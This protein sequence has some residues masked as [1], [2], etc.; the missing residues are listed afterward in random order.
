M[1]LTRRKVVVENAPS[2]RGPV[3]SCES[4]SRC[5]PLE[6]NRPHTWVSYLPVEG[7]ETGLAGVERVTVA[8]AGR[9]QHNTPPRGSGH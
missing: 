7:R 9:S 3:E 4:V 2:P 8:T 5:S 6:S 1:T